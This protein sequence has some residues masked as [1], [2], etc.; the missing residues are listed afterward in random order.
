MKTLLLIIALAITVN[1]APVKHRRTKS[2]SRSH[3]R[4]VVNL[5]GG[6]Y[7]VAGGTGLVR[8]RRVRKAGN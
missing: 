5:G 6:S 4:K 8:P 2:H 1:A 7:Y 3:A